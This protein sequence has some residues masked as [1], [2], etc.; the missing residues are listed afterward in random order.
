VRVPR[1]LH[2]AGWLQAIASSAPRL[3]IQVMRRVLGFEGL[4]ETFVSADDVRMGK[5]DPEVFLTAA[6]RL[7]VPPRR[8]IVVE[9]AAAGIEAA[10]RAGMRCIGVGGGGA[11]AGADLAVRSQPTCHPARSRSCCRSRHSCPPVRHRPLRRCRPG[12]SAQPPGAPP[13]GSRLE[14]LTMIPRTAGP[15]VLLFA[16]TMSLLAL[17]PRCARAQG[18]GFGAE[19]V[20]SGPITATVDASRIGAHIDPLLYG[21]FIENLGNIFEGGLWAEMLGDRKF[22]DPVTEDTAAPR[23]GRFRLV[24]RWRPLAG[25]RVDMDSA[26]AWV[27][28]H[29]PSVALDPGSARGI[30]QRGLGLIEGK[31]Y[32]GRI[33]LAADGRAKVAVE[34][35]W[36][37]G[38][39]DRQTVTISP[40][41]KYTTYPFRFTSPATNRDGRLEISATGTGTLR[42]G[43]VSLMP[44]DNVEGFRPDMIAL[45]KSVHPAMLRW[46]GNFSSGYDW[47][48]G[49]G[50]RDQRP[51]RWDYAWNVVE[52][53]DVGTFEVLALNRLLGSE[54]NIGVNSGLGDA[55]T[56][57]EWVEYVNG[58]ASTPMGRLRAQHGHPQPFGVKWWGIGNE[59]YGDWQLGHMSIDHYVLKHNAFAEAM[60]AVDPSIV[61]VASGATPFEMGTTARHNRKPLRDR[62]YAYESPEDWS[63]RLL[64]GAY[65]NFDYLA[66]HIYAVPDQAFDEGLQEFWPVQ[67]PVQNRLRRIPNRVKAAGE[68]WEEYQRRMP[69]LKDTRIRMVLDEYS[70]GGAGAG[71]MPG[72]LATAMT[73]HEMMRA[74]ELWAMSAYTA[75]TGLI[76]YDRTGAPPAMRATGFLFKL[77]TEHLGSLPLAVTGDSPQPELRGTIGVDKPRVSSG[78]PTYPVDVVATLSP[79]RKTLTVAV[80]NPSE[81]QQVLN[82]KFQGITPA[83][84]HAWT[85][86]TPD[87]G[88]RTMPGGKPAAT[89]AESQVADAAAPLTIPASSVQLYQFPVQ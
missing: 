56:A 29:S 84:G 28:R 14:A 72:A 43:A 68:A 69:Y 59:M 21:Y 51:P 64:R 55:H 12:C 35:V 39:Q 42:I 4:I 49:I 48:D 7:N 27:G 6:G 3:N 17:A 36:G 10:H 26:H 54:P 83:G 60:R 23:T 52:Q 46:G 24:G 33:V 31:A 81:S 50:P 13:R 11:G 88:A 25:T 53:N 34:L 71:E 76:A 65:R 38:P 47:R 67:D 8:C 57:A 2:A 20:R 9:D 78:S 85:L 58:N 87:A 80:A 75:L 66:E 70:S 32:T 44:A 1:A 19:P 82:L 89:V 40:A 5:P 74:S 62:P 41:S 77:Y 45:L 63:G 16:V 30:Q 73:L 18:P 79:D 22:Y 37:S 61:L 86:S 15:R